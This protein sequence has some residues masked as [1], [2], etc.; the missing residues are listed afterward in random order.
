[1]DHSQDH[2][3]NR[4][5]HIERLL[6]DLEKVLK[7]H[8]ETGPDLDAKAWNI[9]RFTGAIFGVA[10]AIATFNKDSVNLTGF[11]VGLFLAFFVQ[12]VQMWFLWMAIRP[13]EYV[14]PPGNP[15]V[16]RRN[17]IDLSYG[18]FMDIYVNVNTDSY[19]GQ[20]LVDYIGN[21][22]DAGAIQLA[23]AVNQRK[24]D[25]LNLM[26]LSLFFIILILLLTLIISVVL[27]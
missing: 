15:I 4:V 6:S 22:E 25:A 19:L 26:T 23:Q 27:A 18:Q 7:S 12:V 5:E 3:A 8:I 11:A 14:I 13:K 2:E 10:I 24:A 1:M 9:L 20:L 16:P 21:E 17:D